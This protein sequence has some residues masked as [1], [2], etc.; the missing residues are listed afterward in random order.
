MHIHIPSQC[1]T[2]HINTYTGALPLYP[3]MSHPHS[4][5]EKEAKARKADLEMPV[6]S[7]EESSVVWR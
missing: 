7:D 3:R 1:S 4:Q 5:A 2:T 6:G